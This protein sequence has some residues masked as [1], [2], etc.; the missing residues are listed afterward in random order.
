MG[1][2]ALL[3]LTLVAP[4]VAVVVTIELVR[5]VRAE[6][7][8]FFVV[9]RMVVGAAEVFRTG[10][11]TTFVVGRMVVDIA[12]VGGTVVVAKIQSQAQTSVAIVSLFATISISSSATGYFYGALQRKLPIL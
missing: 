12:E 3:E 7:A 9:G 5:V 4:A 6:V 10:V 2:V 11:V 1:V 8:F